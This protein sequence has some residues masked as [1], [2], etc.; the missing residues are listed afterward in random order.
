MKWFK[1]DSPLPVGM[2]EFE[3]W[4]KRILDKAGRYADEDS[5]RYALATMILHADAGKGSLPDSYFISRLR[6]AAANQ[7]ASNVFQEI[8]QKQEQKQKE[9]A[10]ATTVLEVVSSDGTEEKKA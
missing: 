3:A 7:V 6:K 8:K 5:M 9:A 4:S 10:E 2:T 1:K